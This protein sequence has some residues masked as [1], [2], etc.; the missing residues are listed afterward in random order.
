MII[1][2]WLEVCFSYTPFSLSLNLHNTERGVEL[3]ERHISC[4]IEAKAGLQFVA[5][6]GQV[7][8]Q[9]AVGVRYFI[10]SI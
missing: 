9:A 3:S 6:E 2:P 1:V 4:T 8:A 7:C 5:G 10:V